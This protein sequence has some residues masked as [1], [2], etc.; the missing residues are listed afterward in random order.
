SAWACA[1]SAWALAAFAWVLASA[2]A[3]AAF[4]GDSRLGCLLTTVSG[5]RSLNER[6]CLALDH[7]TAAQRA[8]VGERSHAGDPRGTRYCPEASSKSTSTILVCHQEG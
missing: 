6:T 5:L 8:A 3:L 2:W 7:K 4:T 1:A